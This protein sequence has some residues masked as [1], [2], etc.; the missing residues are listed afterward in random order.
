MSH[1]SALAAGHLQG[2]YYRSDVCS[3]TS[4]GVADALCI[5]FKL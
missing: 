3:S 4:A 5:P 2:S 1:I